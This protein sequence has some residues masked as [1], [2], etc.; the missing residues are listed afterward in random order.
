MSKIKMLAAAG[1]AAFALSA[2]A[3]Q[4]LKPQPV[5]QVQSQTERNKANVLAFYDLAFNQ[6]KLQEATDKY[7]AEPYIQHNPQVADGGKAFVDA[8]SPL[9]KEY[10]QSHVTI[11]R[12]IADGDFVWLH[13]HSQNHA[14]DLGEAVIDIF[15]LDGNGKI[16]EHWDVVQSVPA[17]TVSGHSM[18]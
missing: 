10:P 9:F 8:M 16:V 17:K 1:I 4:S 18:F 2:C 13:L 6:H 14:Q 5:A 15:R 3:G 11:K 7:V 12:V